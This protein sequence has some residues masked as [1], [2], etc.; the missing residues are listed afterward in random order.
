VE[1][2]FL[3]L[4]AIHALDLQDDPTTHQVA[5]QL[6]DHSLESGWDM[7]SGGFYYAGKEKDGE[8]TILND[9]KS[10]WGAI[11]GL[12]ALVLMH[13]LYPEDPRDYYGK[14]LQQW[15]YIDKN[16]IDKKNGGWYNVGIDQRPETVEQLK[17]H[18]W[19][20]T[21]HNVRGM[22]HCIEMLRS[23]PGP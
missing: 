6:V 9:Q 4:E 14:A 8:V 7:D 10:W 22:V 13:T 23:Q 17:S 1:T 21:Y 3:L 2:A 12:N 18:P 20:T 16:L 19:K 5:K 15:D 11:E